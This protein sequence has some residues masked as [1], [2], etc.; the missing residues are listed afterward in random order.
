MEQSCLSLNKRSLSQ[1]HKY[2]M[3]NEGTCCC[4]CDHHY[5]YPTHLLCHPTHHETSE[6]SVISLL[7]EGRI[8]AHDAL[9]VRIYK[10]RG[11]SQY[12][13][14]QKVRKPPWLGAQTNHCE[15]KLAGLHQILPRIYVEEGAKRKE[16]GCLYRWWCQ[17]I[18]NAFLRP[19]AA[20]GSGKTKPNRWGKAKG[21]RK[22]WDLVV[23]KDV[24]LLP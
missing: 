5:H 11:H 21:F 1:L 16:L 13:L 24:P 8:G 17:T 3:A 14:G 23:S 7:L 22:E 15:T 20:G 4:C 12:T 2:S 10:I 6:G 9:Y 18:T 19:L